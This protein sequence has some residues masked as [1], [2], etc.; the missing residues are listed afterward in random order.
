MDDSKVMIQI[1]ASFTDDSRGII[2][3]P[4]MFIV[5]VSCQFSYRIAKPSSIDTGTSF[6]QFSWDVLIRVSGRVM[7]TL[8]KYITQWS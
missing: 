6:N 5:L 4:K 3:Y 8:K 7:D 2:F 1:V